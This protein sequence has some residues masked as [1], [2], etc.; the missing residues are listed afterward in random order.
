MSNITKLG[1]V[2]LNYN[3]STDTI[4][5]IKSIKEVNHESKIIVVDN[6]SQSDDYNNLLNNL[7]SDIFVLRT[8]K[9]LGYAGGNNVGIQK[10]LELQCEYICVLNNDTI[11]SEDIFTPCIAKLDEDHDLAFV[12]PVILDYK[13][14][15]VQSAGSSVNPTNGIV[16]NFNYNKKIQDLD[17]QIYCDYVSGACIFC[18][19]DIIEH[20]GLIPES[21]FLFFEETEWCFRAKRNGYKNLCLGNIAIYHKGSV[22]INKVSGLQTYLMFRNTIAFMRRNTEHK[23][24]SYMIFK[25]RCIRDSLK[26]I[27]RHEQR[28][29]DYINA[30]KDGWYKRIN[31][32]YPFI[33][34]KND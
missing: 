27:V 29:L 31:K 15:L 32:K 7:S 16:K 3:G 13:T 5:C 8:E 12:G 10:A 25:Y 28:Y 34:I 4:E 21:Y 26:Y 23:A 33:L 1:I 22:S 6:Y 14:G 30:Y 17:E 24:L 11:V 2:I 18:R 19:K 20:E 9:N